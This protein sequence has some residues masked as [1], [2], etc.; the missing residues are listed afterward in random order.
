MA[1]DNSVKSPQI[2]ARLAGLLYLIVILGG[3]FAEIFVRGRLVVYGDTAATAHNIMTHELL[4]RLGFSAEVFY[5]ACNI[6]LIIIF[7]YLF[8]VVNKG[9]T[10][11]VVFFSIVGTAIESVSLLC[12]YAPLVLLGGGHNLSV[13]TTEQLQGWSYL[14]IQLFEYGFAIT[15]VFFGF[16]CFA[17]GYLIFK[18][19]FLPRIIGVL[20]AMEGL[21]YLIN[22][23]ANFLAPEF[24]PRVF[25]FLAVSA[26]AEIS[27]CLWLL[28]F[29]VNVQKW[30]EKASAG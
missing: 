4:Y 27:L 9:I 24:A 18:S 20:M 29:G 17:I 3:L 15:L 21:F 23:F 8:R 11:L 6:P 25:P 2:Y 1:N 30:K 14:S 22:S 19:T 16:Y 10:L 28:L 5:C 26:V 7:Y 13:F 12:H